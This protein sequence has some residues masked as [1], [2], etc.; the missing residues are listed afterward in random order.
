MTLSE[1]LKVFFTAAAPISELRGAIP[2]A[3]LDLKISWPLAFAVAFA[4]NMLPVPFLLLLLGPISRILSRVPALDRILQWIFSISRKRGGIVERYGLVG[5]VLFV[6][7]PAPVT[8]AW[9]GSIVAFLLGIEFKRAFLAIMLG[10]FIA[11]VIVTSL[12]VIGWWGAV[13]AG[14]GFAVLIVI[15]FLRGRNESSVTGDGGKEVVD[16]I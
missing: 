6:A 2:L 10:V 13:I 12:T 9:T 11:G 4:G 8:G 7:I 14:V 15:A 1:F 3:I 16:E 5:L